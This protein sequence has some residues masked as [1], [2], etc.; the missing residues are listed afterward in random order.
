MEGN[1]PKMAKAAD[2]IETAG[3]VEVAEAAEY[4][5][6]AVGSKNRK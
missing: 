6:A 2:A 4:V 3:A 5:E 1:E